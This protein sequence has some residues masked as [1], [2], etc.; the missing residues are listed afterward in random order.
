MPSILERLRKRTLSSQ[1]DASTQSATLPASPPLIPGAAPP[2]LSPSR[3]EPMLVDRR[4]V[5][6]LPALLGSLQVDDPPD[7]GLKP[8]RLRKRSGLRA[9][10]LGLMND[11]P[12]AEDVDRPTEK[13]NE[14]FSPAATTAAPGPSAWKGKQRASRLSQ[15]LTSGSPWPTFGRHRQ[16]P[17]RSPYGTSR[18]PSGRSSRMASSDSG[19]LH[20]VSTSAELN[21]ASNLA[22]SASVDHRTNSRPTES[23]RDVSILSTLTGS[24]SN[25]SSRSKR[26]GAITFG[27]RSPVYD[28]AQRSVPGM[29]PGAD[30]SAYTSMPALPGTYSN[31]SVH[32]RGNTFPRRSK[33]RN[34]RS[35]SRSRSPRREL[36]PQ[37]TNP[38]RF[39]DFTASEMRAPHETPEM[40]ANGEHLAASVPAAQISV[41]AQGPRLPSGNAEPRAGHASGGGPSGGPCSPS[42]L[43]PPSLSSPTS[44]TLLHAENHSG[45]VP[46]HL[47][48]SSPNNTTYPSEREERGG[49]AHQQNAVDTQTR[50]SSDTR[51]PVRRGSGLASYKDTPSRARSK[52]ISQLSGQGALLASSSSSSSASSRQ[53]GGAG[54]STAAFPSIT[55][56]APSS[57]QRIP[58]TPRTAT[59]PMLRSVSEKSYDPSV[60]ETPLNHKGKRKAED[61]DLTPPDQRTGH[62]T[63]FVIPTDGRRSHHVSEVSKPPSS[64]HGRKRARLSTSGASPSASPAHSRP[65]STQPHL[66]DSWSSRTG[67]PFLGLHRATSKTGS[68]TRSG[69]PESM[70]TNAQRQPSS[71]AQSRADRR[72]SM[73]EISFPISALVAPH[74]P[75]MSIRSGGYH[76]RDPRKPPRI[77]PTSWSLHLPSVEEQGSP[78]HA[79]CFFMGF[80]L[81]PLWW[82]ASFW[83][84]PPTRVVGGTDT[85]KAVALDDPQVEHDARSWRLRCRIM[86][87]VSIFTYIPFIVL[88]AVLVPRR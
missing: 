45:G 42:R 5:E 64:Y 27:R 52:R 32:L 49:M 84:I 48:R 10:A 13:E 66:M 56:P 55:T 86:S 83:R 38:S 67:A 57:P 34:T 26:S 69:R 61:V 63:T 65:G 82:F 73:S 11:T 23:S 85:E 19:A 4:I 12:L 30:T 47:S 7:S 40:I 88:I 76:M 21:T 78:V 20:G 33:R 62:H 60:L 50:R 53:N 36:P 54:P 41:G 37:F 17:T 58:R 1:S 68:S 14:G 70:S 29:P 71:L 79:W 24:L 74:A 46:D 15:Q 44:P 6:D 2:T 51:E 8:P 31:E 3:S 59:E 25:G 81:F 43:I 9:L 28:M 77:R 18:P 75:S 22:S 35:R 39:H 16:R 87:A 80:I 72:R